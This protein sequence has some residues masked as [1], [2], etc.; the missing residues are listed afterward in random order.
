MV[1]SNLLMNGTALLLSFP[2]PHEYYPSRRLVSMNTT[3]PLS[4]LNYKIL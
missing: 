3:T 1:A 2:T 4:L